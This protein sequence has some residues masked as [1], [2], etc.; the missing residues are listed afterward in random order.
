MPNVPD[1]IAIPFDDEGASRR[2]AAGPNMADA[3][4]GTKRKCLS[5]GA[6]FFDLRHDPIICP[7]CQ[8]VFTPMP[9]PR[10]PT[11]KKMQSLVEAAPP[12]LLKAEAEGDAD[13]E[14]EITDN[15]DDSEAAEEADDDILPL[16]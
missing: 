4:L 5:C 7:K 8:A 2:R 3:A 12:T 6:P 1:Y 9:M 10:S 11:H 14:R 13:D 15:P 16:E